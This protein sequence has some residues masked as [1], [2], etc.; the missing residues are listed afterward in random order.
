MF[1][2]IDIWRN[3]FVIVVKL[4]K[5]ISNFIFY[6]FLF[7]GDFTNDFK[8]K[9]NF[10][11]SIVL[12]YNTIKK[13]MKIKIILFVFM[14]IIIAAC[15][16]ENN[17][18]NAINTMPE[19]NAIAVTHA[20]GKKLFLLYCATCHHPTNMGTGPALKGAIDRMPNKDWIYDWIKNPAGV[21]AKNDAYAVELCAKWTPAIMTA[22][23]NLSNSQIDEITAYIESY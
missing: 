1:L 7:F 19:Q 13:I 18:T 12:I 21:L 22:F 2:S 4:F 5:T 9:C 15:D 20:E 3:I 11:N 16:T 10:V 14:A 8:I 23:H 17:S 6:K